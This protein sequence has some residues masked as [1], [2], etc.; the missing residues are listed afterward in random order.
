M[1][2]SKIGAR[3]GWVV[4]LVATAVLEAGVGLIATPAGASPHA[5]AR[6]ATGVPAHTASSLTSIKSDVTA[7]LQPNFVVVA[8]STSTYGSVLVVGG[9]LAER[10]G[11]ARAPLFEFSGDA[12]GK[13]GCTSR[14]A[15][16]WD[17]AGGNP[18]TYTCTGPMSDFINSVTT[19]DWPAFT[20]TATP[21]AG[22]GVNQRL[23]GTVDRPG[24]GRQV[25]YAGHPLYLFDPPSVPLMPAGEDYFE[26]V[27]QMLPWHGLWR[28]VSS[29]GGQPVAGAATIETRPCPT[30]RLPSLPRSS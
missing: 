26:T 20:T 14:R 29:E 27:A 24:I 16:G 10:S 4:V 19:D 11:V 17:V 6:T 9:K 22:S 7:E 12:G 25:T 2:N 21:Q 8:L 15:S 1:K 28:L 3:P 30:A 5:P 23:L 13:F 18:G